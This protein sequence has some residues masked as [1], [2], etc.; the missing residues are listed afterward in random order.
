VTDHYDVVIIGT[1]F[2]ASFFLMRYLEHAAPNARILVLE[3]GNED[4]KAWQ[5]ANRKHSSIPPEDVYE[6]DNLLKDWL[7]SPGFGGNS[8]CWMGG[9]TRMMP[10]DF[11]LKSRY[12]VGMDWPMSYDDL[13]PHYCTAEQVMLISGPSDSPMR[14]SIP[15]PLPPHR[16]S[17]PDVLLKKRF[18]DGWYQMA[19]SRASIATGKR[20]VCCATGLCALCPVDA[21][22]TIQNGL[23]YLYKDPRVELRLR[24]EV[25]TIDTAAGVVQGVNYIQDGVPKRDTGDLMILGASALF[26]PHILLR[27]GFDHPLIGRRLHEQMSV[28]VTLDLKGVKAYNGSTVLTGLGYLFYDGEHRRDHAACMI[29]TWNSPFA[30]RT[31]DSLRLES[32]RWNERLML[33]FLFDDIPSEENT[34]TVST[35]NPR[36]AKVHFTNFSEYAMKGARRIPQM[37]DKLSEALPIERLLT[38]TLGS[39]AAHIQGTVVMGTDPA[40]SVV[41]R[42]LIHHKYRNLLVLGS[43]S[44]PTASPA[45]PSL[46][47]S[48]LS[49]WAADHVLG[50]DS[51]T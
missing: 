26:N 14:R 28:Y 47:V 19:T 20:G 29:E 16:F 39:T 44:Y 7:T 32:G 48:A 25:Q 30:N 31:D 22:F 45:Y 9:T 21:K 23:A 8:K 35:S 37:V 5:L 46:T 6:N 3:R 1:S 4:S 50:L 17:D 11:Q 36:L 12:G 27:S 40:T 2:A 38:V 43:S 41:D 49:L 34:V 51:K 24:S 10:G 13:E 42:H 18:P 33:G 15:F